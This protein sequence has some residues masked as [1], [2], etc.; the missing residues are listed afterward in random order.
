LLAVGVGCFVV[1]PLVD[2]V[3]VVLV[4]AD[5]GDWSEASTWDAVFSR[6]LAARTGVFEAVLADDAD[7]ELPGR[8]EVPVQNFYFHAS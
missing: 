8:H 5:A 6:K 2:A 4:A 3:Q 7:V 1:G